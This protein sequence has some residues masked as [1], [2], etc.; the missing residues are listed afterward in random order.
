MA[1]LP[2]AATRLPTRIV[3]FE[4]R[5]VIKMGGELYPDPWQPYRPRYRGG[6]K[7]ASGQAVEAPVVV[8]GGGFDLEIDL[9]DQGRL[10]GDAAIKV[11]AGTRPLASWSLGEEKGW[12]TLTLQGSS[13]PQE[14]PLRVEVIDPI[15]REDPTS[16]VLDRARFR[17]Q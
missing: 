8:G 2:V 13:W 12:R 14:A 1:A 9:L 3:E 5:Q 16:L 11:S 10:P 15:D 7:L 17:W 4:D 6:W